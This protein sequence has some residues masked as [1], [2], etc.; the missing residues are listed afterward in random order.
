MSSRSTLTTIV[1]AGS[2][3]SSVSV[4]PGTAASR[5][6]LALVTAML[7]IETDASVAVTALS[8]ALS[9]EMLSL[10]VSAKVTVPAVN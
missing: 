10:S 7:L 5:V 9:P 8:A 4:T 3:C 2:F 1:F 6:L